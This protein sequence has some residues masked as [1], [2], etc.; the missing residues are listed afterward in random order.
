[1]GI[2]DIEIGEDFDFEQMLNESFENSENNSVVDGVIVEITSENVL[3]DVGQ[4]IEGRLYYLKSQL[5]ATFNLKKVIQSL[6]C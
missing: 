5:M 2:E 4:K 1:M 3:V 6:L